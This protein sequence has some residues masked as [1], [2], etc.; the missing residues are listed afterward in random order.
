MVEKQISTFP[1]KKLGEGCWEVDMEGNKVNVATRADAQLIALIP[2]EIDKTYTNT[3]GSAD[4][5]KVKK[6][7]EVC[8]SYRINNSAIRQLRAWFNNST[9]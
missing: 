7:V 2:V 9:I 6:I 4:S 3:P 1:I 5:N 8:K